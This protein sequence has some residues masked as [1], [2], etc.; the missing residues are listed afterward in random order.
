MKYFV[1]EEFLYCSLKNIRKVIIAFLLSLV[2]IICMGLAITLIIQT[3]GQVKKYQETFEEKQYYSILDNF[4]ST[5]GSELTGEKSLS[6]LKTFLNSIRNS[7]YFD[8]YMMYDQQVYIENYKGNEKNIY[9]YEHRANIDQMNI[10][11][12]ADDDTAKLCT[13]VKGFW[14]GENVLADFD[15][16]L[17]G[18]KFF[19][20]KDFILTT[21][22]P[23]SVIL[24]SN[25]SDE[26]EV[27]ENIYVDFIFA[28]R[29]AKI[30]GILEEGSN[31]YYRGN[32]VN[33]DRFVILP[34]FLND[35]YNEQSI[36]RFETNHFYTLR[37]S[38]LI[39]TKLSMEDIQE[40]ITEYSS[41]A[42]FK[43]SYYIT[44]YDGTSKKTFGLG[45]ID[46]QFLLIIVSVLIT[47]IALTMLT[48]FYLD[49]IKKNKRYYAILM[50]NGSN[51]RQIFGILLC[52]IVF[53][54]IMAY[55]LGTGIVVF[56]SPLT[57]IAVF[58]TAVLLSFGTTIF[59]LVPLLSSAVAFFKSDLI[60]Y[61]M[62]E[63]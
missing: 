54:L 39:A 52:E 37:N 6:N 33:L 38:G 46:I 44:E 11:I 61:M 47:I 48:I 31:L 60:S 27:G 9:G 32:Y 23:I 53:I 25:Y 14:L 34:I 7:E 16:H 24:G 36:Y 30:I 18:G 56:L 15:L 29:E 35:E 50:M 10:K 58:K 49:K 45:I 1:I 62:E 8:Y 59:G 2:G 26:Y 28:G 40:I 55:V 63:I 43:T 5:N 51:K 20:E 3:N 17:Q 4:M 41:E 57:D 42:G 12:L 22:E 19:Q 21:T 13:C